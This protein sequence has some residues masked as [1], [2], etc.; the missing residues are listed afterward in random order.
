MSDL[1]APAEE[2][3]LFPTSYEFNSDRERGQ[4]CSDQGYKVDMKKSKLLRDYSGKLTN[5]QVVRIL[6]GDS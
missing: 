4:A 3:P 2:Q 1:R 6:S 5:E